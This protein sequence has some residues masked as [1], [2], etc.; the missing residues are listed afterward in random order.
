MSVNSLGE[1]QS[2]PMSAR[3]MFQVQ[4]HSLGSRERIRLELRGD[5]SANRVDDSTLKVIG[6]GTS[7]SIVLKPVT[8]KDFGPGRSAQIIVTRGRPGS[9]SAQSV[10]FPRVTLD[11]RSEVVV[12]V[13][14][15]DGEIM[16]LRAEGL[17]AEGRLDGAAATV[18]AGLRSALDAAS[19]RPGDGLGVR[20]HV[21][22]SAS[23]SAPS[24]LAKVGTAVDVIVGVA[25][26]ITPE[27]RVTVIVDGDSRV[28]DSVTDLG[29]ETRRLIE[30]GA[31]RVGGGETVRDGLDE[32]TFV[33][34]DAV[35]AAVADGKSNAV[36]LLLR[37]ETRTSASTVLAI[38]ERLIEALESGRSNAIG[39]AVEVIVTALSRVSGDPGATAAHVSAAP[40][41][42]TP[43]EP[44]R[45][46]IVEQ[47]PTTRLTAAPSQ[48][49]PS[50]PG[51]FSNQFGANDPGYGD[52]SVPDQDPFATPPAFGEETPAFG[53]EPAFGTPPAFGEEPAFGA[54]AGFGEEPAFDA[55]AGFGEEPNFGTPPAFGQPPTFEEPA[56]PGTPPAFGAP[57]SFDAGAEA[58]ADAPTTHFEVPTREGAH[59]RRPR[60]AASEAPDAPEA[61]AAPDAPAAPEQR[62]PAHE[63]VRPPMFG[64]P[65]DD[66]SQ[67]DDRR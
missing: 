64:V 39:D 18:R 53:E 20:V 13:I 37:G 2:I 27:P 50:R 54:P 7:S 60:H 40:D 45:M 3:G 21:D 1:G 49:E 58:D 47:A 29:A 22:R 16:T 23:M 61:P 31:A 24:V 38:D 44:E 9:D 17:A 34:S 10:E 32:L 35:P 46:P 55:P 25:S 4:V 65:A 28:L 51:Q 48:R 14:T 26:V 15:S 57:P 63:D 36:A 11:G 42:P 62:R 6:A 67:K 5:A 43:G 19:V 12:G 33:I 56:D 30:S 8:G 66:R 59:S 52:T 41:D